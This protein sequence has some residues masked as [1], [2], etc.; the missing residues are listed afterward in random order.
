MM[1]DHFQTKAQNDHGYLIRTSGTNNCR[2]EQLYSHTLFWIVIKSEIKR[3]C[4]IRSANKYKYVTARE[5]KCAIGILHMFWLLA[6]FPGLFFVRLMLLC[7]YFYFFGCICIF[8]NATALAA[9]SI[10]LKCAIQLDSEF[11]KNIYSWFTSLN[12]T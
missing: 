8:L 2:R 3:R 12:C 10:L 7:L 11:K 9:V 5:K 6:Y 1:I 4:W